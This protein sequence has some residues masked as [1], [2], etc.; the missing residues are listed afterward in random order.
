MARSNEDRGSKFG[1]MAAGA[2]MVTLAIVSF[3]AMLWVLMAILR[4]L[5]G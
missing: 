3:L 1:N 4:L 2:A 5:L